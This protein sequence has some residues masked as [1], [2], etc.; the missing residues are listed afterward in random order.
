MPV[1][2]ISAITC[3][4]LRGNVGNNV[5]TLQC[6]VLWASKKRCQ[7]SL[8]L[9]LTCHQSCPAGCHL[10]CLQSLIS[11]QIH[12]SR[13]PHISGPVCRPFLPIPPRCSCIKTLNV[14]RTC[15]LMLMLMLLLHDTQLQCDP[16]SAHL[17][18]RRMNVYDPIILCKFMDDTKTCLLAYTLYGNVTFRVEEVQRW[19]R[20]RSLSQ[21]VWRR[22]NPTISI[23]QSFSAWGTNSS[24]LTSR[25]TNL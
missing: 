10:Y 22:A 24:V 15:M 20:P 13:V 5:D 6:C 3:S 11:H 12:N 14:F 23:I 1:V 4:V 9:K 25:N 16:D 7:H 2:S 8:F 19:E 21:E 18:K 17:H